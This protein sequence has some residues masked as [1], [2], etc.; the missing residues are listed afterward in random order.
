MRPSAVWSVLR[1]PQYP[2]LKLSGLS[3]YVSQRRVKVPL[4]EAVLACLLEPPGGR[5]CILLVGGAVVRWIPVA[6]DRGVDLD[7]G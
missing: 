4:Q 2:P 6:E 1:H 3:L 7:D 5:V